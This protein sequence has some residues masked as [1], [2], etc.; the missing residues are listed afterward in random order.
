[1]FIIVADTLQQ[2]ILKA[3][4]DP[5]NQLSHPVYP[6]FPPSILQYAEDTLVITHASPLASKKLKQILDDF[7]DATGRPMH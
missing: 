6:E 1:M 7:A 5:A 4:S 2:M 3:A